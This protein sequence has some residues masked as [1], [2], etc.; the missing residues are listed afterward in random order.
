MLKPKEMSEI[1]L[2]KDNYYSLIV[3]GV[4]VGGT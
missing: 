1:T 3:D 2:K 4:Y